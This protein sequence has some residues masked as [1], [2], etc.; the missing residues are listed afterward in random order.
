[1]QSHTYARIKRNIEQRERNARVTRARDE[2]ILCDDVRHTFASIIIKR[3]R[4]RDVHHC[5]SCAYAY[6]RT[7]KQHDTHD[8]ANVNAS[9]VQTTKRSQ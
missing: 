8:D 9:R 2:S 3:A 1:M 7:L 4:R 6:I 5:T